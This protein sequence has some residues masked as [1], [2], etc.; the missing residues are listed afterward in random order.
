M[1]SLFWIIL[2]IFIHWVADFVLQPG[3]LQT[4][5]KRDYIT[6]HCQSYATSFSIMTLGLWIAIGA[7]G[8]GHKLEDLAAF[9][10]ICVLTHSL[11][12]YILIPV[13]YKYKNNL[14]MLGLSW[15]LDQV[16]HVSIVIA[17]TW[18]FLL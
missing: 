13:L 11:I 5:Q 12:D 10:L 9:L 4:D 17:C 18:Y 1:L 16:I 6:K 15:A 2:A 3:D 14:K 8:T 7:N